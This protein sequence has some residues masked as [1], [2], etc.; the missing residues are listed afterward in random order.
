MVHIH[1]VCISVYSFFFF[2]FFKRKK[3]HHL[4]YFFNIHLN[5]L[6]QNQDLINRL[7]CVFS[8]INKK[9]I[10]VCIAFSEF[11][12]KSQMI[13]QCD[14][15]NTRLLKC[16][17][18]QYIIYKLLPASSGESFGDRE[19]IPTSVPVTTASL[20]HSHTESNTQTVPDRGRGAGNYEW[21]WSNSPSQEKK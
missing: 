17:L 2:F 3:L 13:L 11:L 1:H 20:S 21:G 19:S 9:K 4:F 14:R 7:H 16:K 15:L 6:R 5:I 8:I 10:K 12:P 18:K